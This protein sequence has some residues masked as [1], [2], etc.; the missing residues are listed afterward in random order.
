MQS[1]K[2][3]CEPTKVSVRQ[4]YLPFP[5]LSFAVWNINVKKLLLVYNGAK[6]IYFERKKKKAFITLNTKIVILYIN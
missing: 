3:G 6:A 4:P 5:V 1:W 2:R